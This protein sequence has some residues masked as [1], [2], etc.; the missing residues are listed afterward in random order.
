MTRRREVARADRVLPGVWRL[1]LPLPWPGVPH[2]NAWAVAAGSGVVLFD[3]GIGGTG[4]L[5][6]LELALDQAGLRLE[7]VR[8]V[9][10]THAHSDHYGLAG[11]IVDA[12]GCE[13]WMHPS[14]HHMTGRVDDPD[15]ML[16]RRME[17][18]RQSGV[19]EEIVRQYESRRG[20][21][22]GVDRVVLPDRELMPGVEVETDLGAWHVY[23]TPGHA[24]S[25]V[26]LH[27]PERDLLISGDHLLGRVS[28]YYDWG[29]TPDP[30]GE[31]LSSLDVVDRL[32][33]RLCLAGHARPF[34][35]VRAH[36][37]ANRRTVHERIE[38]VR[39]ALAGGAKTPFEIVPALV[40][41]DDITPM[42]LNWG[43]N[44]TLC[45]LRYLELREGVR[46]VAEDGAEAE[47][48]ELAA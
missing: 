28:L 14:H 24:P 8:L 4:A 11:P 21:P 30:A 5:R 37:D 18:A 44:E 29:Y 12:A 26:C 23:E 39:G 31:F 35:D 2:G 16:E 15:K 43:L 22:I 20:E 1:R 46:K 3:T 17:V 32:D 40:G 36:V 7:H 38:R 34:R 42:L 25:H 27:Q 33:A 41:T 10:C 45:Y 47:R 9:V 13:L 48:W 19:P 6:Q